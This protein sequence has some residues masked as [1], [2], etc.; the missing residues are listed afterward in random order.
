M[1]FDGDARAIDVEHEQTRPGMAGQRRTKRNR[2]MAAEINFN[3]GSEL[4]DPPGIALGRRKNGF[5]IADVRR[6]L[7][8]HGRFG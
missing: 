4:L 8:H 6:N 1:T 5:R 7:L 3:L 2:R